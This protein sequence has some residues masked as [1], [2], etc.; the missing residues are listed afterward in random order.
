MK[1]ENSNLK[2]G[3]D[4]R[5]EAVFIPSNFVSLQ[6]VLKVHVHNMQHE[7]EAEIMI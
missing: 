4:N 2:K 5:L 6:I 3:N 1:S 7:P